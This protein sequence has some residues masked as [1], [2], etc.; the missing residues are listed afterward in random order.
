MPKRDVIG[1][2]DFNYFNFKDRGFIS[3]KKDLIFINI[4]FFIKK[5]YKFLINASEDVKTVIISYFYIFL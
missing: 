2:F 5:L 1:V 4:L 3:E